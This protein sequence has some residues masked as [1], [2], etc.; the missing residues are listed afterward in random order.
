[1][2]KVYGQTAYYKRIKLS[3]RL[4]DQLREN[5]VST[6]A[7]KNFRKMEFKCKFKFIQTVKDLKQ[8]LYNKIFTLSHVEHSKVCKKQ[9]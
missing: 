4:I 7:I 9:N 2:I 8:R 6:G 1:M 5:L 3:T